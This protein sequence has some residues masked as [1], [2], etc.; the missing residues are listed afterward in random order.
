[1]AYIYALKIVHNETVHF[2]FIAVGHF[3]S[4]ILGAQVAFI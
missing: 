4:T 1:L 3:D 2:T